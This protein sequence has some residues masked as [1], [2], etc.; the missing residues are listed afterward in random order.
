[1]SKIGGERNVFYEEYVSKW[2]Q[3]LR[4][5]IRSSLLGK[6]ETQSKKD[7]RLID[8]IVT[9]TKY[10]MTIASTVLDVAIIRYYTELKNI[11][12]DEYLN[13]NWQGKYPEG[14]FKIFTK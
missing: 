10:N 1:M 5:A 14:T 4:Q 7:L 2:E 13:L 9:N 6:V 3:P 11:F 12:L 8:T